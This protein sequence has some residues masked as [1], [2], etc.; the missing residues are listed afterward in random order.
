MD[1]CYDTLVEH[2]LYSVLTLLNSEFDN[3]HCTI[4]QD[5][6]SLQS[7]RNRTGD[8]YHHN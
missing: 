1:D 5:L 8:N 3:P 7:S 6:A 2:T 4:M